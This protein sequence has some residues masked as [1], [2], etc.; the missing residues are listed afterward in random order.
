[1]VAERE[2]QMLQAA[3]LYYELEL[4]QAAIARRMNLTRWTVGRL[5]KEA[6]ACGLVR[7]EIASN[8]A[9]RTDLEAA[10]QRRFDLLEA[11][12]IPTGGLNDDAMLREPLA[13]AAADYLT[14]LKPPLLAVSW[15]RTMAAVAQSVPMGWNPDVHVV[16]MNGSTSRTSTPVHASRVAEN[17]AAAGPGATTL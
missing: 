8:G 4:T 6:R 9:R 17:L 11:I 13:R 15:G 3:K 2:S 16:M 10:L 12:V 1:M 14:S 5:L 7:I